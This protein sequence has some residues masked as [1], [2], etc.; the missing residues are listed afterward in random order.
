MTP[1]NPSSQGQPLDAP[2]AAGDRPEGRRIPGDRLA[3]LW[4]SEVPKV[5][6]RHEAERLQVRK[7]LGLIS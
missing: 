4:L 5:V 6:Q 3:S 1:E 7:A 2:D